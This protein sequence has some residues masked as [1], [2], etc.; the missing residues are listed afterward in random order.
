M[1]YKLTPGCGQTDQPTLLIPT[2]A[3]SLSSHSLSSLSSTLSAFGLDD[4]MTL[5]SHCVPSPCDSTSDLWITYHQASRSQRA[6]TAQLVDVTDMLDLEDVLDHIFQ[7]GFVDPKW[8]SV[9][10][11]EEG[12]STRLKASHSVQ[13][14]LT[15]GIGN[16]PATAL[17]L[18]IGMCQC[19]FFFPGN[20]ADSE[21]VQR[22]LLLPFGCT[23]NTYTVR[24]RMCI[25]IIITLRRSASASTRLR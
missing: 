18:I 17:R 14:L 10:W 3:S 1:S 5:P 23:M 6:V 11:W 24:M 19:P 8:R 25:I 7:Q 20:R 22:T 4:D 13:D 2:I 16:T 21:D 15:R 12:A 9:S